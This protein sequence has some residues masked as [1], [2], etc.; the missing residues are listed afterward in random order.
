E[1]ELASQPDLDKEI[2]DKRW[3]ELHRRNAKLV[4]QHILKYRGFLTKIGQ[5]A[6]SKAGSLPA[7]WVEELRSLQD[8][9]PISNFQEVVRTIQTDLGRPLQD[10]FENFGQKPIAS[11]SVGQA[12]VANLRSNR[13]KVCVK[14]QHHGV[15][16]L[17]TADLKT[18][19]FIAGR[20]AKYHPDAPDFSDLIREW[21]RASKEEVDFLLEAKNA[22]DASKALQK[23]GIDVVCPMPISEYCGKRVLTMVFIEGWKITDVDKM[24]YG[25]DRET[26]A[27]NLV[28]AFAVLVFQEG[29]IHGDPHPGNVFVEPVKTNNGDTQVRP[30]LLDWGI[31]KRLEKDERIAAAKWIVATLAQDRLLY[32][33]SLRDLGFEFDADPDMPEFATFVE[34]SLG[35][36]A[37]MFRDSI[38]SNSQMNFL[39]Q[40]QQHQEKAESQ[41]SKTGK[42]QSRLIGKIPGVV[43][44]FLRGLEML[45]NICGMLE[46]TVPFA[47]IMLDSCMPLLQSQGRWSPL[48]AMPY[49]PGCSALEQKVRAKLQALDDQHLILAAQVAVL[50]QKG[51]V[52]CK[53]SCGRVAVCHGAAISD[54]TVMPLLSLSAGPLLMSLLRALTQPSE[55]G[56]AVALSSPVAHLWPDFTQKGKSATIEDVLRHQ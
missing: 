52:M 46:V 38:P 43:L 35:Q 7:P 4:H 30:V 5:A 41:E 48:A 45:Q 29:L 8:E 34:A 26:M 42:D 16:S 40:M 50:D 36:C 10:I 31:V 3:T 28:H 21:R 1:H 17:M 6:S 14:V 44:F 24:P 37:F 19:E 15:G 53:A 23:R 12:H 47:T 33:N 11:A 25:T 32:V 55:T 56:K 13:K 39:Q 54:E 22:T 9:L 51:E 18:V 2:V 27:R 20:M 49:P